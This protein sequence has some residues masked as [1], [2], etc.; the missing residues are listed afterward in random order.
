MR[1]VLD[2]EH[3][4]EVVLR[5]FV[6]ADK[7]LAGQWFKL[8]GVIPFFPSMDKTVK[9]YEQIIKNGAFS[10][11]APYAQLRIGAAQEKRM[12][13]A[14]DAAAKAYDLAADRYSD[15]PLGTDGMYKAGQAYQKQAKRA[16]YDQSVAGQAISTFSDFLTLHPNDKRVP[17][18]QKQMDQLRTEQA[19][20]SF[21]IAQFYEKRR[22]W[23][24]AR[25]YYNDALR[26]DPGSKYADEALRRIDAINKRR[27]Q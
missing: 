18:A 8:W 2:R 9:L 6:I 10:R 15:Q 21:A 24:G 11:V 5:Q 1:L 26:K 22:Q 25:V 12:A 7:F 14:Y 23:E 13:P 27:Q 4:D 16:E 17:E 3:Y 20:G 19:R